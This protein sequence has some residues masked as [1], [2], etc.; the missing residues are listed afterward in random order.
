MGN[1]I[2]YD[3]DDSPQLSSAAYV[4]RPS[5][6][7]PYISRF[8]ESVWSRSPGPLSPGLDPAGD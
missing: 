3:D 7:T 8:G 2:R 4:K 1:S 5:L 6:P